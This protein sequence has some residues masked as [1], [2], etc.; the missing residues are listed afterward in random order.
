MYSGDR[1]GLTIC[2]G[3]IRQSTCFREGPH[4]KDCIEHAGATLQ[5]PIV[6]TDNPDRLDIL[7]T[8]VAT[9]ATAHTPLCAMFCLFPLTPS[10]TTY[11]Y[12]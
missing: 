9:H 5:M 1:G 7:S 6:Q 8:D 3:Q 10:W 11:H 12:E 2:M 4:S